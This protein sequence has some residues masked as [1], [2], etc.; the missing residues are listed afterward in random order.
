MRGLLRASVL[1]LLLTLVACRAP[2]DPALDEHIEAQRSKPK[3]ESA[4][5]AT[6]NEPPAPAARKRD[7]K[8]PPP[9]GQVERRVYT[10]EEIAAVLGSVPGDGKTLELSLE[11]PEGTIRCALDPESAPQTVVNVVALAN[12]RRP[13]RDPDTGDVAR[14][15][16]YDGLTFHRTI[17]NFIIQTGNPSATGAGGPGWT[18]TREDGLKD[19]YSAGGVLAMVDAGEDSHGSQFFITTR[20]SSSLEGRYT[21]FGT[22]DNPELVK[23][24]A[25]AEKHPPKA[26]GKSATRSLKPTRIPRTSLKRI[27]K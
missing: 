18:I 21:P 1:L 15:R 13:W 14:G 25:D 26:E 6:E 23:K 22:C 19:A 4:K 20:A 24:I 3:T 12:G 27:Q 2:R 10:D 16:F 7:P 9:K 8:A 11:T 5:K 17:A